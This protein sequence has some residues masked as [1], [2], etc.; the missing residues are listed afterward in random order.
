MTKKQTVLVVEDDKSLL[1]A[2]K[3][4]LEKNGFNVITAKNGRVGLE[5]A[6]SKHPNLILTDLMMP[7]MDGFTMIEKIRKDKWGEKV[8]IIILSVLTEAEHV[9]KAMENNVYDFLGKSDWK[10][11][12][13]IL[14][15]KE[16]LGQ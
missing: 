6:L 13:V 5:I 12:D 4:K 7:I 8:E 3:I 9:E 10:I 11:K 1:D 15:V 2:L 14:A 16:K